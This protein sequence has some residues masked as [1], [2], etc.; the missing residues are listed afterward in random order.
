MWM[1][2]AFALVLAGLLLAPL[3]LELSA[4]VPGQW[5]LAVRYLGLAF[6]LAPKRGQPS[7]QAATGG[8]KPPPAGR[9]RPAGGRPFSLREGWALLQACLPRLWRPVRF[10][11]RGL[12]VD[13]VKLCWQVSRGDAAATAV[14]FGR[15]NAGVYGGLAFLHNFVHLS[16]DKVQIQPDFDAPPGDRVSGAVRLWARP[17]VVL[18][19]GANLAWMVGC[20]ALSVWRDKRGARRASR[21]AAPA[22][23]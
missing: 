20:A 3:A 16:V 21:A 23:G 15:A 17:A 14:G 6:R 22:K 7:S 1:A 11:L 12:H 19:V 5:Q 13:R 10:L 8:Q 9:A 4:E 2:A 18:A